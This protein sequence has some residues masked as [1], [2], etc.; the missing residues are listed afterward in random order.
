M[1]RQNHRPQSPSLNPLFRMGNILQNNI[2]FDHVRD[3]VKTI[4]NSGKRGG[5]DETQSLTIIKNYFSELSDAIFNACSEYYNNDSLS[6]LVN[7]EVQDRLLEVS[8]V[9]EI[10]RVT[11]TYVRKLIN[12]GKISSQN[13]G[14]RMT[15]IKES[16]LKRYRESKG[17]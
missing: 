17:S 5:I 10:L 8:E 1:D 14:Q 4:V 16:D 11:P 2:E 15:R 3:F 9:A 6:N 7:V 12:T 13:F